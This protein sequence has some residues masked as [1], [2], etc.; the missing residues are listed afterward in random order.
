MRPETIAKI[1]S[2]G[3]SVYM[4]KLADSYCI[5]TDGTRLGYFQENSG[6]GGFTMSSVHMPNQRTGTGFQVARHVDYF[7]KRLL[8]ECLATHCPNWSRGD[9]GT[10]KKYRDIEHYRNRDT[11]NAE[12]QLV[13]R[14]M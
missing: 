7:D 6:F 12:Y 2:L 5:F 10:V 4:R 3:F 13:A 9:E 14:V 8:E 11:W 1:Q